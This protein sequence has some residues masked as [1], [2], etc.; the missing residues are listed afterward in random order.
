MFCILAFIVFGILGIFSASY[1]AL[2]KEAWLCVK[3][4][5][6]LKPCDTSLSE[7]IRAKAVGPLILKHPK[8]AKSI[9]RYFE[10]LSWSVVIL[11]IISTFYVS[12]SVYNLVRYQSCNPVNPEKCLLGVEACINKDAG[13]FFNGLKRILNI[14]SIDKKFYSPLGRTF[15]NQEAKITI[16]EF[17]C[18]ECPA[19]AVTGPIVKKAIE[20]CIRKGYIKRNSAQDGTFLMDEP[21][22]KKLISWAYYPKLF[23]ANKYVDYVVVAILAAFVGKILLPELTE[24]Y[25]LIFRK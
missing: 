3:K 1:R 14:E 9:N 20:S 15:G 11:S 13:S 12:Q 10:I 17:M 2:A 18:P 8:I 23:F 5:I 21:E 7:K 19:C 25:K 6:T 22:A 4:R 24:L 16:I